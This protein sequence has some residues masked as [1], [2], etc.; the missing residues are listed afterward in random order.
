M[1]EL[2]INYIQKL[3]KRA[4][5]NIRMK[6]LKY[7]LLLIILPNVEHIFRMYF[8]LESKDC[9]SVEKFLNHYKLAYIVFSF[10]ILIIIVIIFK[11]FKYFKRNYNSNGEIKLIFFLFLLGQ[12]FF[13]VGWLSP[14]YDCLLD[15]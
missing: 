15:R 10:E 7:I 6:K 3:I 9:L 13:I 8:D 12:I 2:G 5:K 1:T 14:L 4:E 11:L